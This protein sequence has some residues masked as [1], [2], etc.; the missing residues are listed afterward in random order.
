MDTKMRILIVDNGFIPVHLYGGTQRVIW[1]LGK[2]LAKMGHIV[3]F[4]VK[5]GSYCDFATVLHIDENI[6][7]VDQIKPQYD[8]VHFNFQPER[9]EHFR[10]PYIITMHGNRNDTVQL[11]KNTVFVSKNHA[12]RFSSEA[13]VYNGLDWE[14]YAKPDLG[15]KRMYFHFL[16]KASW[17]IKNVQGAIDVVSCM[18][19]ERLAVLGGVRFNIKMGVRFTFSL[20]VTFRGMVGGE[21]KYRW[22]N[23]SKGLVFP[24]RW[25][26]P[27]GLA[28]IESLYY[29]CPV[30]GTPYGSLPELVNSDVGFLSDKGKVLEQAMVHWDQYD[31]KNCHAYALEEFNS[32]RMALAY[33]SKYEIV[34]ENRTINATNPQLKE[35]QQHKFLHWE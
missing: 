22:L 25:H 10:L 20:K 12:Q 27:F 16:G 26:E 19:K 4:L 14:E 11:D 23:G 8:I 21:E 15:L 17:R 18:K 1:G 29:G 6:P 35:V 28:I 30:F 34:L 32:K 2:E 3:T 31:P 24:V 9:I 33:L 7:I 13:Y 5:K